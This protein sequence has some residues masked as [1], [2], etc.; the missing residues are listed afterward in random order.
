MLTMAGTVLTVELLSLKHRYPSNIF[1]V[2]ETYTED[3]RM[4][5]KQIERM[6]MF[7]KT[8][9]MYCLYSTQ[10]SKKS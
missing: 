7:I 5:M 1:V 10:I 3:P 6:F 9:Q 2:L 8:N 4:P